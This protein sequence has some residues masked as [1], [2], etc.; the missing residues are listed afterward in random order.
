MSRSDPNTTCHQYHLGFRTLPDFI[1]KR[2]LHSRI[3]PLNSSMRRE[4]ALWNIFT[5]Q[6]LSSGVVNWWASWPSEKING[7]LVSDRVIYY[8]EKTKLGFEH[9]DSGLTYP[10]ELNDEL[11]SL[12]LSPQEV[13]D[14]DYQRY[15]AISAEEVRRMRQAQYHYFVIDSEFAYCISL[16]E[17]TRRIAERLMEER[18]EMS[19]WA[20]YTKGIDILSHTALK[21]SLR[22][23]NPGVSAEEKGKYGRV[24]DQAYIDADRLVG[25]IVKRSDPNSVFLV[26]SDHGFEREADGQYDHHF[27]PPGVVVMA[28]GP[29]QKGAVFRQPSVFDVAPTILYLMGLPVAKDMPGRPWTEILSPEFVRAYPVR[30]IESYGP[31]HPPPPP[32]PSPE[33]DKDILEHL[34][35]LGYIK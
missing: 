27:A 31:Y 7:I 15:M 29:V 19:F 24:I 14:A 20:V 12:L 9:A 18:P 16:Q 28:G 17:S 13:S 5:E 21:Y 6:G 8:R 22:V 26:V 32:V 3:Y 34:K 23:N 30:S 1:M 11:G 33:Q 25:E 2:L 35:A 4:K 10:P